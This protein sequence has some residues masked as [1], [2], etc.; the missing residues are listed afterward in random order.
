MKTKDYR[1]KLEREREKLNRL[2]DKAL[3]NG[4]PI[5]GT[6]EIMAQSRKVNELM[7]KY[8]AGEDEEQG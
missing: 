8:T 5:S 2:V 6:Y 4:T 7:L 1:T 3:E